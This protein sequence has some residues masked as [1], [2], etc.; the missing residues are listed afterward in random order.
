MNNK[1][2]EPQGKEITIRVPDTY[3]ITK[4]YNQCIKRVLSF[5]YDLL[6]KEREGKLCFKLCLTAKNDTRHEESCVTKRD[7]IEETKNIFR[8]W[9]EEHRYEKH[10]S[11]DRTSNY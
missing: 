3:N 10:P 1:L 2:W 7:V 8:R 5:N 6:C 9:I 11:M 4:S